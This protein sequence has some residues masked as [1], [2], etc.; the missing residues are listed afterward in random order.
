[1]A[2]HF[3]PPR[4][5]E[6]TFSRSVAKLWARANPC[7]LQN[8]SAMDWPQG[9][10]P[11]VWQ[12]FKRAPSLVVGGAKVFVGERRDDT[13]LPGF[14]T[15]T[16]GLKTGTGVCVGSVTATPTFPGPVR[17]RIARFEGSV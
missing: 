11:T 10:P 14:S 6:C 17:T 2:T 9:T 13:C 7:S 15:T 1:M 8:A 12:A 4:V 16:P 5:S 3:W